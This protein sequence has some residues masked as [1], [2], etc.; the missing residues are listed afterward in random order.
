MKD[1]IR[2]I[3]RRGNWESRK[4]KTNTSP[5]PSPQSGEGEG[6]LKDER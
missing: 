5:P 2:H 4:L 1:K 6:K 3:S